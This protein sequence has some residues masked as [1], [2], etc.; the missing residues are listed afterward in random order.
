VARKKTIFDAV[1]SGSPSRVKRFLTLHPESI[2]ERNDEGQSPL[3]AALYAGEPAVVEIL[4]ERGASPDHFEA[5]ALGDVELLGRQLRRSGKRA[6]A[7]SKDGFTALH[8]AAFYGHADAAALLLAHGAD[9]EAE[10][11]NE[12]LPLARPLHSAVAGRRPLEVATVLL[13]GGADPNATQ[14]GGWTALHSAALNGDLALVQLL[15]SK[16]ALAWIEA[17]DMTRPLDFAI[18]R[19]HA[20]IVRLLQKQPKRKAAVARAGSASRS[21]RRSS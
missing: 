10:S 8:Y 7:Y 4:L 15:L 17:Y 16:G 12:K 21:R 1:A 14:S 6:T 19:R 13:D 2:S 20:E 9:V 18:E 5:A 11:R 3:M